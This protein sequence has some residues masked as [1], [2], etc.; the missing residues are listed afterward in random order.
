MPCRSLF[1]RLALFL[2]LLSNAAILASAQTVDAIDPAL[3]SKVDRIAA[4]VLEATD[5]PSASIAIVQHGKLVYTHAYGSARLATATT[6]AVPETPE[7]R[8]SIG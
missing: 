7:M 4:Q 8:Y 5:V 6:P 2:L 3:R 1:V